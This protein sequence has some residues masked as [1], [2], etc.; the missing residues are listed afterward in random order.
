MVG[1]AMMISALYTADDDIVMQVV[2]REEYVIYASKTGFPLP[3]EQW[4]E[5]EDE[6]AEE[7][8]PFLI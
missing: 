1:P 7:Q 6:R 8:G 3:Y 2:L 5:R 4:V